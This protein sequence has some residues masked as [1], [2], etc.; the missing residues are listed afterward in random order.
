MLAHF[1]GQGK[2][3]N[4]PRQ[5]ELFLEG[6]FREALH[7]GLE[8]TGHQE[9][10]L[11]R[12]AANFE[13][14]SNSR[15]GNC[16]EINPGCQVLDTGQHQRIVMCVVS[17]MTTQ[18]T[19]AAFSR[20]V[21]PARDAVVEQQYHACIQCRRQARDPVGSGKADFRHETVGK[22]RPDLF[23]DCLYGACQPRRCGSL[24]K[25]ESSWPFSNT[26][27]HHTAVAAHEAFHR[28]CIQHLIGEDDA[29][30]CS[31]RRIQPVNA[32]HEVRHALPQAHF[33]ALPQISG[34]LEDVVRGRQ[35]IHAAQR[36]EHVGC[37]PATAGTILEDLA[38]ICLL[39][40]LCALPRNHSAEH[41]RHLRRRYKVARLAKLGR[42]GRVVAEPGC[43]QRMLHELCE[44]DPATRRRYSLTDIRRDALAVRGAH[45]IRSWQ[46]WRLI[47]WHVN[48]T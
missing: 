3:F 38:A 35:R 48:I 39:K 4:L 15:L 18:P 42:A 33:L 23:F 25:L 27:L 20:V 41:G 12:V 24:D 7:L 26:L 13:T 8:A 30:R 2:C 10:R 43:I 21:F 32:F 1:S 44:T 36:C 40:H 46:C 34:H 31:G 11:R 22:F 28:Q 47:V 29:T 9:L 5:F 19:I 17:E 37:E 45:C 14:S 16:R 6:Q